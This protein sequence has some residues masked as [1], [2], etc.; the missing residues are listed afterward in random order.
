MTFKLRR[1]FVILAGLSL[2]LGALL[3]AAQAQEMGTFD[4]GDSTNDPN[5]CF[6]VPDPE[7]CD[8]TRG[9]YQAA[10]N[11][12]HITLE[13]ARS[14]YPDMQVTNWR[15]GPPEPDVERDEQVQAQLDRYED[16]DPTNDPNLCF[17]S[18]DP[19]CDW[20]QGWYGAIYQIAGIIPPEELPSRVLTVFVGEWPEHLLEQRMREERERERDTGGGTTTT[21]YG[22][23]PPGTEPVFTRGRPT[24]CE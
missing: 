18:N 2:L 4:D 16:D 5:V 23:C 3:P 11:L 7:N 15:P 8:W 21:I 12:G 14:V 24:T 20:V 13:A 1:D 9:W 19:N 22:L 17:E 6:T 10:V